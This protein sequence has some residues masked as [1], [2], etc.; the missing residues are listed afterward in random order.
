MYLAPGML[1]L[2]RAVWLRPAEGIHSTWTHAV[3]SYRRRL[4]A[5]AP[6]ELV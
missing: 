3:E 6:E 4:D 1:A 2:H 5:G